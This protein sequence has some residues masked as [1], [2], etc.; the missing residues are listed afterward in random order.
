VPGQFRGMPRLGIEVQV[1]LES[2][3]RHYRSLSDDELSALKREELIEAAQK[4]LDEE[5]ERRGLDAMQEPDTLQDD[6][7]YDHTSFETPVNADWLEDA[8]CACS[9]VSQPG[10]SAASDAENALR[11][12][13]DAGIPCQVSAVEA[14]PATGDQPAQH[15]YRVMVPGALNLEAASI[16]DQ[17]VFNPQLEADW[18]AHFESLTDRELAALH[19]DVICAGLFD[20]IERLKKAYNDEVSRRFRH[21]SGSD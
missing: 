4:C 7:G 11:A 9:F 13:Q 19:P 6:E 12:L 2:L 17:E 1:D 15:E 10:G 14:A 5:W 3:R 20:R 16:L 8:A 18:R 21:S